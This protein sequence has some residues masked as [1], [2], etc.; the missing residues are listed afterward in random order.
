VKGILLAGGSGTRLHPMTLAISK[1]LLPIYDKPMVYHPLTTLML[2]GLREILVITTPHDQAQF[3]TLLGD[4]SQW[5]IDLHYAV[6]PRPDGLAQAFLI[7]EDFLAGSPA[8][9][10]L[11]DN[12]FHGYGLTGKL[13]DAANLTSG[14]RIFAYRV[15]DPERYGVVT[16]GE[17]GV[18]TDI[19]E[20]PA[21]PK[22]HHA[23]TGLYFYGPDVVDVAKSITPST[24][25]ELEI[26]DVNRHYLERG[27]LTVETL[28][29]GTAWLDTGTPDALLQAATF[30]QT[31]EARQGI[32]I[33]APEE[34]AWRNGWIDDDALLEAAQRLSKNGYGA[35]LTSLTKETQST[36]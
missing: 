23:V 17:D 34:V 18:A 27:E 7:G 9:L 26:T 32:K 28:G 6:Q 1:Q 4:G 35:Y 31:L 15:H 8:A 33:A 2:A 3:Q 25:G 10:I 14:A 22:S 36:S 29:R 12:L 21:R 19:E 13:R 30:V 24:R 16:F 11:G 5:G 20:K